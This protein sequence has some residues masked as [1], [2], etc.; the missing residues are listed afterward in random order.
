MSDVA[1][2]RRA[3]EESVKV[4]DCRLACSVAETVARVL[5]HHLGRADEAEGI[6]TV[7]HGDGLTVGHLAN[8]LRRRR[9]AK[10][11]VRGEA[12]RAS[13]WDEEATRQR[14]SRGRQKEI[15]RRSS[16]VFFVARAAVKNS[17]G[18]SC[19]EG[20]R[21]QQRTQSSGAEAAAASRTCP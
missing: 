21:Q 14:T 3:R 6:S 9:Q 20:K 16:G 1:W 4:S 18:G 11:S 13:G 8:H 7:V 12:Q 2:Y 5:L 17:G 15:G 19:S 10:V